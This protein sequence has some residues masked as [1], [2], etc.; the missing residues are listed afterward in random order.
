MWSN[1]YIGASLADVDGPSNDTLRLHDV[2]FGASVTPDGRSIEGGRLQAM[3]DTRDWPAPDGYAT[4]CEA[5][6]EHYIWCKACPDDGYEACTA[7]RVEH[8]SGVPSSA[9]TTRVTAANA[10]ANPSCG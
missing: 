3:V 7:L 6:A 10:S 5:L 4:V 1:P 8:I 2:S 9:P